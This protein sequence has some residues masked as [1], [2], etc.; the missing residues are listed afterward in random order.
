MCKPQMCTFLDIIK[1]NIIKICVRLF[2]KNIYFCQYRNWFSRNNT[3]ADIA[4]Q[5]LV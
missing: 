5:M 1:E 2:I 3:I 4:W